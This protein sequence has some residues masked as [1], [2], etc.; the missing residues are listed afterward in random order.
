[1]TREGEVRWTTFSIFSGQPRW[2]S[3]GIQLGGV[4]SSK[5]VGNWF[6][7]CVLPITNL[8]HGFHGGLSSVVRSC[9]NTRVYRDYDPSGPCGPTAFWKIGDRHPSVDDNRRS[10]LSI[11][12]SA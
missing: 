8:Q 11:L 10:F 6:D 2:R 9:P 12:Y 5:V 1:M 7:K 3:E 4:R